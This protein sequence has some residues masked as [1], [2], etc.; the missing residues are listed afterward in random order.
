MA[1]KIK[2]TLRSLKPENLKDSSGDN[3]KMP[4]QTQGQAAQMP[5]ARKP[6]DISDLPLEQQFETDYDKSGNLVP[7]PVHF[8]K[9]QDM[10]G[11]SLDDFTEH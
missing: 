7:D 9:D 2:R 5:E 11:A 3:K 1:D 4:S 10:V 6:S 8:D